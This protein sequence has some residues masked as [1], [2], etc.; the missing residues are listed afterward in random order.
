LITNTYEDLATGVWQKFGLTVDRITW[1]EHYGAQAYG[2]RIDETFDWITPKRQG[3]RLV[4]PQWRPGSRQELEQRIGQPFADV[5]RL[6]VRFIDTRPATVGAQHAAP[7]L[8]E[9]DALAQDLRNGHLGRPVLPKELRAL[10]HRR[11]QEKSVSSQRWSTLIRNHA[12]GILVYDFCMAVTVT[13]RILYVFVVI[14][15]ASR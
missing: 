2:V 8:P 3:D 11:A 5:R 10:I 14:E 6:D 12:K 1:I 7:L 13:F 9:G 15:H 4:S